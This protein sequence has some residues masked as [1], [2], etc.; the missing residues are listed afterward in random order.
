[1]KDVESSKVTRFDHTN[2]SLHIGKMLMCTDVCE[3][4]D[5]YEELG[6]DPQNMLKES[7]NRNSN[8]NG[9]NVSTIYIVR[10]DFKEMSSE[11]YESLPDS[12]KLIRH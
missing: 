2:I 8:N 9:K 1:M 5:A 4:D 6:L 12:M 11:D 10:T 7:V 3:Y